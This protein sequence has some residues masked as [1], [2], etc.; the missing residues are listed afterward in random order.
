MISAAVL[1][2]FEFLGRCPRLSMN[3]APLA[4]VMFALKA[5]SQIS[6]GQRPRV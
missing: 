6:L 4:L 5:R 3:T 1:G 2:L